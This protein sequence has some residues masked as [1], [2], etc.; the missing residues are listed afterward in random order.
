MSTGSIS[1][2]ILLNLVMQ[3]VESGS[4][5]ALGSIRER[6]PSLSEKEAEEIH[7]LLSAGLKDGRNEET[8][9]LV[10]TAP[11]SFS[12]KS[13]TT[14]TTVRD[15]ILHAEKSILITGYSLSGY[16]TDMTDQ[17]IEKSQKGVL[18]K[19][20]AND[21]GNQD[22]IKRLLQYQGRFLEIYDYKDPQDKMSAL[23]AK[24]LSV[25]RKTTLITSANLSYHG[26]EGNIELGIQIDSEAIAK[27][28]EDIFTQLLF[29]KI[30]RKVTEHARKG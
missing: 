29:R 30:F 12:L 4:L 22:Q 20:Y 19:F 14:R 25:D 11:P 24:V 16:F 23:H 26:Q 6:Y 8:A 10:V 13:M 18:V 28:V 9:R 7:R 27:Q 15:M 21:M 17:L 3:D 1:L 2:D 5:D